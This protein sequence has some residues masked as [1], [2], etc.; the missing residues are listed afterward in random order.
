MTQMS[1]HPRFVAANYAFSAIFRTQ[2]YSSSDVF[3]NFQRLI[4]P[5][6]QP[7]WVC[8]LT[9]VVN[10]VFSVPAGVCKL[11]LVA[12]P[13]FAAS[14]FSVFQIRVYK[15]ILISYLLF[16]A[17]MS[18]QPHTGWLSR[19]L[20]SADQSPLCT[21]WPVSYSVAWSEGGGRDRPF[22]FSTYKEWTGLQ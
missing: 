2:R 21:A 1:F 14:G 16:S 11:T 15:L 3:A 18:L 22:V 6:F 12:Q 5:Y 8:K 9:L 13:V 7:G 17:W 4:V 20:C 10:L 19:N